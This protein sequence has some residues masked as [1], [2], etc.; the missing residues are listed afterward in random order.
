MSSDCSRRGLR[1]RGDT[2]R[3]IAGAWLSMSDTKSWPTTALLPTGA[4]PSPASDP[5]ADQDMLRPGTRLDE[6]EIIRVLGAGGFGIVYLALDQVLLRYVAIKEYMP[7][8]LARRR[9]GTQ[10]VSVRSSGLAETFAMGLESFFNEARLLANFDHPS[11]VK[12]HR[13]WKAHGT[14]Y[15]VMQ[16]YPGHTLKEAR[17]G[18]KAPPEESWLRAFVEPLL[19]ALELLHGEDVFHR[20]ISPD[21]ILLLP[22]GRPVL[23]DFGSARR[24]IGDRTQ[25]LTALLKPN[26]APVEQYADEAGMRQGPWTDLYGLGATVHFMLT[27][28]AP[29]PSVLRAVRDVLP[30][31]SAPGGRHFPG[32]TRRFLAAVDWTLALAPDARPQSVESVRQALRGEVAPPPPSPRHPEIARLATGSADERPATIEAA[33]VDFAPTGLLPPTTP[34]SVRATGPT[35]PKRRG[36]GL[37]ALLSIGL[38]GL[39]VLGWSAWTLT[40]SVALSSGGPS[41]AGAVASAVTWAV[42]PATSI[43]PPVA[44]LSSLEPGVEMVVESVF[45]TASAPPPR[46]VAAFAKTRPKAAP[47]VVK[48]SE[49]AAAP[50]SSQRPPRAA[51]PAVVDP[52]QAAPSSLKEICG[53]L[54]FFARAM[55]V[56]RECR[57]PRL[58]AQP[59]CVE[60]RRVEKE[61]QRRMDQQ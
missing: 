56:S 11:L 38:M 37:F 30:A 32:V 23:L 2:L 47:A 34:S 41:S 58:R 19:S 60:I 24:V 22:D 45:E 31:L 4:C 29:A 44:I 14:A 50:V 21:N 35:L 5:S 43:A 51:A 33:A 48:R 46:H 61:R 18:M 13:F 12:V 15:M 53:D 36:A 55:C 26:F 27:G 59:Q 49:P 1:T 6:F 28:K 3:S 9:E 39:G 54:N 52:V 16:Y 40:P 8:A 57:G 20:D 7:T 42:A 10:T 25:S 17:L